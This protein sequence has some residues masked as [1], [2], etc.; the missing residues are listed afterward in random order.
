MCHGGRLLADFSAGTSQRP[1]I[2]EVVAESLTFTVDGRWV[3]WGRKVC[4]RV[5][6]SFRALSGTR[7]PADATA[8]CRRAGDHAAPDPDCTCGFHALS[9]DWC[10]FPIDAPTRLDVMLT[11]RVLAYEFH[12]DRILF[13]AE[14]QTVVHVTDAPAPDL[15]AW[16]LPPDPTGRAARVEQARPRGSGPV[17]LDLP[18]PRVV[19]DDD[20]GFGCSP[21]RTA[22]TRSNAVLATIANGST[23]ERG[24]RSE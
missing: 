23:R 9:G 12:A 8:V 19:I 22:S 6:S 17:R 13:R 7:Y 11:G 20:A 5:G 2:P 21:Y 1:D 18:A 3:I 24:F 4:V 14:R 16:D 10:G 15:L